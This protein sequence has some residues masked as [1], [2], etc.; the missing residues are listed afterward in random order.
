MYHMVTCLQIHIWLEA[1]M[2]TFYF[3]LVNTIL[4]NGQHISPN[5]T[6]LATYVRT[7]T[8]FL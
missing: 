3:T 1:T 8:I 5:F 7:F 6:S 2:Y 4:H